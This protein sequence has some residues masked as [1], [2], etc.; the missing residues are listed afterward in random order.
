MLSGA[1]KPTLHKAFIVQC[2]PNS[3]SWDI[4]AQI[5][6]YAALFLSLQTTMHT[7]CQ[8]QCC[9]NILST[10]SYRK[11]PMQCSPRGS[12]QYCIIKNPV[13]Y[14]LNTTG[15][16]LHNSMEFWPRGS[17]QHCTRKNLCNFVPEAPDRIA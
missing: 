16:T 6:S 7:K 9:L 8:V 15:T 12:K 1:S 17:K 2:C 13:Q 14:C 5:N 11:N 4:I 3:N 10:T